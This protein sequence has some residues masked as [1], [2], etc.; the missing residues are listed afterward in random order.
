M[1]RFW[2]AVAVSSSPSPT[3]TTTSSSRQIISQVA[4]RITRTM[5]WLRTRVIDMVWSGM[6]RATSEVGQ[7]C[8]TR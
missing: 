7:R 1:G 5:R 8:S 6:V 2:C 4:D 3:T